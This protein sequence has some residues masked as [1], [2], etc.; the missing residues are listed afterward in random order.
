[1]MHPSLFQGL[2]F[3]EPMIQVENPSRMSGP[4]QANFAS[5][6]PDIWPSRAVAESELRSSPFFRTWDSRAVDKYMSFGLR[7]VPT[8]V[9]PLSDTTTTPS[10]IT[11]TTSKAQ[12]AW[13]YLNFNVT[14]LSKNSMDNQEYLLGK[15]MSRKVGEGQVNNRSYVT[16]CP[17]AAIAF[18]YLAFLRP[19][20]LYVFGEKSHI[21]RSQRREDKLRVTGTGTGG[22]GG[23]A[24]G[25]VEGIVVPGSSHMLPLEKVS[26]TV[27]L[28]AEWL[29]RQ[30]EN[31]NHEKAFL[32]SYDSG[33]S[34]DNQAKL[35]E[36]WMEYMKKPAGT[37]RPLKPNL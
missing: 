21:N 19:S 31:F 4:T 33:K 29:N 34:K 10:S 14:P 1:M 16:T 36:K 27:T 28:L 15:D 23:T 5:H 25:R 8:A 6:R 9:H 7:S 17:S 18:E 24:E 26:E 2:V 20:I 12:E 32:A 35:S 22:N 13:T 11:L 30:I 37:I 3:L